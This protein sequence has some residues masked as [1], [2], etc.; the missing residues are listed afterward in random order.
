MF[1]FPLTPV[2]IC[3]SSLVVGSNPTC[4]V[5]LKIGLGIQWLKHELKHSLTHSYCKKEMFPLGVL[6]SYRPAFVLN[7]FNSERFLKLRMVLQIA[8]EIVYQAQFFMNHLCHLLNPNSSK[9]EGA[10]FEIFS[11]QF[12]L[13]AVSLWL[14]CQNIQSFVVLPQTDGPRNQNFSLRLLKN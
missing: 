2:V 9:S 10:I 3:E 11:Q 8:T 12:C 6:L 7:F 1:L 13:S 4:K 14:S 5:H